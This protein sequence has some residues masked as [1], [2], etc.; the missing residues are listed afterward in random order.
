MSTDLPSYEQAAALVAADALQLHRTL[1]AV[2]RVGLCQAAG[3][4]LARPLRAD[5]DQPPFARSTRDGF[6]CQAAEASTH[7]PLLLIGSS[8]AGEAPAG[9]LRPALPGRS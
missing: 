1:P 6:A 5:R 4:V 3:R 9:P 8:R 2:E 7:T